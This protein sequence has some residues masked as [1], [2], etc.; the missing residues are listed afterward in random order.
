[1]AVFLA[2]ALA[3]EGE[4]VEVLALGAEET[5]GVVGAEVI[6]G[7][8]A[9]EVALAAVP[10]G[11]GVEGVAEE[12]AGLEEG[13]LGV[14]AL[15]AA[16]AGFEGDAAKVLNVRVLTAEEPGEGASRFG[17]VAVVGF[18]A[19]GA[20]GAVLLTGGFLTVTGATLGLAAV[21][22]VGLA[23]AGAFLGAE[24]KVDVV[25]FAVGFAVGLAVTFAGAEVFG[26][27]LP[28]LATW[29]MVPLACLAV[30]TFSPGCTAGRLRLGS[31]GPPLTC[32]EVF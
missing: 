12:A 7:A 17:L 3:I 30:V 9:F 1:M 8:V 31:G 25:G 18:D 6:F 15:G 5:F 29:F 32:S 24:T 19:G 26:T 14:E 10:E 21:I 20:F 22:P 11:L 16:V 13:V 28:Y 4:A 23:A 27:V 2:P